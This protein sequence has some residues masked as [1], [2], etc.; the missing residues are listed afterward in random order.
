MRWALSL[1][2]LLGL[3]LVPAAGKGGEEGGPARARFAVASGR[4]LVTTARYR[5]TLSADN[6]ALLA[7]VDRRAR[8]ALLRGQNGC[9][10]GAVA[11]DLT[12]VSGCAYRPSGPSRFVYSWSSS[13]STL[14]LRYLPDPNGERRAQATVELRAGPSQIDLRLVL[15]NGW[16]RPLHSVLL[17][18][19]LLAPVPWVKAGYA[20]TFLP[21]VRLRPSFFA[22]PGDN[23]GTYPGRWAFADYLAL[24]L[25]RS[26]LALYSVSPASSPLAPVNLGF[27]RN[28]EPVPCS[29]PV[30]C[31][32]HVFQTWIADGESWSSPLVRLRVGGSARESILAYRRD[33][34]ID[35][36]PSLAEKAG[37]RLPA[38]ARAP[39]VKVDPWKGLPPLREWPAQLS[40]LPSPALL[41]PVAIQPGGHDRS[42]PDFLPPDPR[43]GTQE[44]LASA[45]RAAQALGQLVMPYLNVSW[46]DEQAPA[47]RG[48]PPPLQPAAIAVRTSSGEAV[49]EQFGMHDGIVVSPWPSP[50]R[51]RV[52]ALMEE[53]REQ[54]PVDCLFFD[55]IG[56]RPWRR[57]FNPAAPSPLAY[58]DGWLSLLAPYKDRCLMV[59]DGWDRLAA[60]VA[61]FHGGIL[62]MQREFSWPDRHWGE[63]TWEPY[64]LALWLLHDKVLFYQHDLYEGTL[65]EDAE[66]L[67]FNLAFGLV[68]SGRWEPGAEKA[69]WLE[70][71]GRLQ[72]LLGPYYAGRPFLSYRYLAPSVTESE[73][74]GGYTVVVNWT[75]EDPFDLDGYRIAPLGFLARA[76]DGRFLAGA[77]G[78][79]WRGVV[80]GEGSR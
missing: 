11:T 77:L 48:L 8:I 10:W 46:W 45:V 61:G 58:A 54:V 20:P 60:S 41:H 1:A 70:L 80:L 76:D 71:A 21:G 62:L 75:R 29:G 55:Q 15:E 42:Y 2:A 66:A 63:D 65:T 32:T 26:H 14:V 78:D 51:R 31:L 7:L 39:L 69:S 4:I 30:F 13:T 36:Y 17:P 50:V 24:D 59:E 47:V 35:R 43:W 79:A 57:D 6:G 9:L 27:V 18:A 56:A 22:R 64:P 5:L 67:A 37:G 25:G 68:L 16:G 28:R 49:R 72:R 74:G 53:W 3:L 34:G 12:T 44:E 23:V 52:E 19:D 73:F 40:R 38:L 33:N